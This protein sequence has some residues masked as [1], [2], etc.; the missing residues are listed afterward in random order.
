MKKITAIV[1][2]LALTLSAVTLGAVNTFAAISI[3]TTLSDQYD[4][5][6]SDT[7]NFAT[8]TMWD[9]ALR[10]AG[11]S[12]SAEL[13]NVN[14]PQGLTN[15]VYIE[16]NGITAT[17]KAGN[18]CI[19]FVD[20]ADP[21][22]RYSYGSLFGTETLSQYDGI[23]LWI[24]KGTTFEP[25]TNRVQVQIGSMTQGGTYN[26]GLAG[27]FYVA[28]CTPLSNTGNYYYIPF[29]D[30]M[31]STVA[32]DP[33]T[34]T[35]LNFISFKTGASNN[36][37]IQ[38]YYVGD[39]RLYRNKQAAV[40]N[41]YVRS[42]IFNTSTNAMWDNNVREGRRLDSGNVISDTYMTVNTDPAHLPAGS[43][44]AQSLHLV[45]DWTSTSSAYPAMHFILDASGTGNYGT[46]NRPLW[47]GTDFVNTK[48]IRIW[49]KRTSS[50]MQ[51]INIVIA[52]AGYTTAATGGNTKLYRYKLSNASLTGAYYDIPFSAF[53]N[54]SASEPYDP[55][56][57]G[58][59]NA[60]G[61]KSDATSVGMDF[62]FADLQLIRDPVA[63]YEYVP[64][65][66]FRDADNTFLANTFN[67]DGQGNTTVVVDSS[68]F[69]ADPDK[70]TPNTDHSI[71]ATS[72]IG[73]FPGFAFLERKNTTSGASMGL[74]WSEEEFAGA[75]GI[76]VWLKRNASTTP[77]LNIYIGKYATDIT[78]HI[79]LSDMGIH[80]RYKVLANPSLDGGA[81]YDIPFSSFLTPTGSVAYD[82]VAQGAP[83]W[84]AFRSDTTTAN[85]NPMN[86]WIA[87]LQIYRKE[88]DPT[89]SSAVT[90]KA[91]S[92]SYLTLKNYQTGGSLTQ[93]R[94]GEKVRVDVSGLP[95]E[96]IV[97]N[98]LLQ[99][100]YKGKTYPVSQRMNKGAGNDDGSADSFFFTMPDD[101]AEVFLSTAPSDTDSLYTA[102]QNALRVYD[103]AAIQGAG[104]F[105]S[106][107]DFTSRVLKQVGYD[108]EEY[109]L[110]RKGAILINDASFEANE[111]YADWLLPGGLTFNSVT[112]KAGALE[113]S[114][115]LFDDY[116]V[117]I[118]EIVEKGHANTSYNVIAYG[119]YENGAGETIRLYSEP[120]EISYNEALRSQGETIKTLL[121]NKRVLWLGTSIPAG[122]QTNNN[123]Y[124]YMVGEM[125]GVS[126]MYNMAVGSSP[127]AAGKY[128]R[129]DAGNGDPTGVKYTHWQMGSYGLSQTVAEKQNL[130]NNF[131]SF[132]F[133]QE[134]GS[135][136]EQEKAKI[137]GTSYER[138][139]DPYISGNGQ[140]DVVMYNHGYNDYGFFGENDM[141]YGGLASADRSTFYGATNFILN[142]IKAANP[143]VQIIIVG[144]YS[145]LGRDG[146]PSDRPAVNEALKAYA[147]EYGYPYLDIAPLLGD[148][149]YTT[150]S[151]QVHPHGDTTQTANKKIAEA[152]T[153]T[154]TTIDLSER[155]LSKG[156]VDGDTLM[157]SKDIV[158][159]KKHILVMETLTGAAKKAADFDG[160]GEVTVADL[161]LGK[162]MMV[163]NQLVSDDVEQNQQNGVFPM[164]GNTASYEKGGNI[165]DDGEEYLNYNALKKAEVT[166]I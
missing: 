37:Q 73:S 113:D 10:E 62:Y 11:A 41:E 45:N 79:N 28:T 60:I 165:P 141:Q 101:D 27:N 49:A 20:N 89:P 65:G 142:R 16:Y 2:T 15:S 139:V 57:Q 149:F 120:Y 77:A 55:A 115:N 61:F 86:Y 109:T 129:V 48:G 29:S 69:P 18:P 36:A 90:V 159:M 163:G 94:A 150:F 127:A 133:Y 140:V 9:N 92:S 105:T 128:D 119:E 117:S 114:C 70:T 72:N 51:P 91:A 34:I 21:A 123:N 25:Y 157:N 153:D 30:F 67:F 12:I 132:D 31:N 112:Q 43:N 84:I 1:L 161:V 33:L 110:L 74:I 143:N 80:P 83:S 13:N 118:K 59:P 154:L 17:N 144:H 19:N 7:F 125:A 122:T 46:A 4:Y 40:Q 160:D 3:Q 98:G 95:V 14:V 38:Q 124:P 155:E 147:E 82:P 71:H 76:R 164:F 26:P 78:N 22:H 156:D 104:A 50:A 85:A 102:G 87:D 97:K 148:D 145:D 96:T 166:A 35:S 42:D 88:T 137:V 23:V 151:D 93:A 130:I 116:T 107:L 111:T 136:N 126:A 52:P 44:A 162:K 108:G 131:A 135:R 32:F 146:V 63:R 100:R 54:Y 5:F 8:Q 24:K 81:Y 64:S 56:I 121:E 53:V 99:Y 75:E 106:A 66:I 6:S 158:L 68:V 152:I 103:A 134:P 138:R 58:I 39:L 47:S